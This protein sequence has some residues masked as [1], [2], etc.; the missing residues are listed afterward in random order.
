MDRQASVPTILGDLKGGRRWS[1]FQVDFLNNA[2]TVR[3]R[4]TKFGSITHAR[5]SCIS[6]VSGV[7][8]A[9]V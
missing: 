1:I 2:R 9:R 3:L 5:E 8:I 4:T 6:R 7:P